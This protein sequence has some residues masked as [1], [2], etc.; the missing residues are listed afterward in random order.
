MLCWNIDTIDARDLDLE[1][2]TWT[3]ELKTW[4][5]DLDL[6]SD[7]GLDYKSGWLIRAPAHPG[8]PG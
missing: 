6:D 2:K 8:I 1:S 3:W 5:L 4:D 7:R